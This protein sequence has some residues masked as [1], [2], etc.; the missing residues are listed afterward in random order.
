MSNSKSDE[1]PV[2]PGNPLKRSTQIV[3]YMSHLKAG[4]NSSFL[5]LEKA[6]RRRFAI[7]PHI[8]FF[9]TLLGVFG[10]TLR[11][12]DNN[13]SSVEISALLHVKGVYPVTRLTRGCSTENPVKI[14]SELGNMLDQLCQLVGSK[15]SPPQCSNHLR[16]DPDNILHFVENRIMHVVTDFG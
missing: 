16:L 12:T 1:S 4:R 3:S 8:W 2:Y 11:Q 6:E 15:Y 10:A 7:F 5:V 9:S 14:A 13:H